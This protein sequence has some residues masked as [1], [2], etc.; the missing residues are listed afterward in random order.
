MLAA[1]PATPAVPPARGADD[2]D[3]ATR[4][5]TL[6]VRV[7]VAAEEAIGFL[8]DLGRHVGLHPFLEAATVTAADPDGSWQEWW[9]VERPAVG[10]VR[11][12]IR[13][14]ARVERLGPVAL[15]TT[16]QPLAGCRLVTR[17]AAGGREGG[18]STVV[19]TCT[20]TAPWPLAGY[21]AREARRAHRRTFALLP[22][23]LGE[24]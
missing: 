15:R 3:V 22:A 6:T 5:F 13:F 9:V 20:V 14:A 7:P 8:G 2:G 11:Y 10:P 23:A 21:I 12:R 4:S 24:R 16:V 18:P 1:N 17:T 19:E